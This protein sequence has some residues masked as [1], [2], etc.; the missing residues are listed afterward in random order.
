M[1]GWIA[2]QRYL[3]SSSCFTHLTS[4][5]L[6]KSTSLCF[7][8]DTS[9]VP[10][11]LQ[12][13]TSMLKLGYD[14]A[15]GAGGL[16]E[17]WTLA[18]GFPVTAGKVDFILPTD[19]EQRDDYVVVLFGDSGNISKHF[20]IVPASDGQANFDDN[21]GQPDLPYAPK[22]GQDE[23]KAPSTT[24]ESTTNDSTTDAPAADAP[25]NAPT[26]GSQG[27]IAEILNL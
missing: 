16:N 11:E 23:Q 12:D 15:D 26:T 13:S 14:P 25:A 4:I 18:E 20:S 24:D 6:T 27:L 3:V 8:R 2:V 19:L 7:A 1:D 5:S 9:D 21:K 22:D 10:E 17:H